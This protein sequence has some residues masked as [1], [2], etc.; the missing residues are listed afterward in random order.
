M[1]GQDFNFYPG[2]RIIGKWHRKQYELIRKIG[3]GAQGTVYLALSDGK[4][5]AIK[6]ARD[7]ASLIAEVN[8]LKQFEQLQG[9]PLGPSLY[10]NDDW[11]YGGETIG[12]CAMEYLKGTPASEAL[13]K[14]SF[15]WTIVFLV[16]LLNQLKKLHESGYIFADLK[17]EN[18]IIIDPGHR[19]RCVDF[20][21]ATKIGRSVREYTEFYDRGYWGMGTRKAEPS[22]DLFACAMI[23]IDAATGGRF[24]RSSY[25]QDQLLRKVKQA[26]RLVPYQSI[27]I[28]AL[29]GRFASAE[30]MRQALVSQAMESQHPS[31]QMRRR[32]VSATAKSQRNDGWFSAWLTA[33]IMLTIYIVCVL[34]YTM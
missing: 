1:T 25:P 2:T 6:L 17:P 29:S 11:L 20:G 5:M 19:I 24:E 7:R 21:G 13:K 27:I 31:T 32:G 3:S 12:F 30:E 22:Y 15:D 4:K 28:K 26:S 16:Q 33:S 34:V 8:V 23:L 9:N 10:D 14:R 18:L